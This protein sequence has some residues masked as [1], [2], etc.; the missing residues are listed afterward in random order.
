[1]EKEPQK[2]SSR[3]ALPQ[4]WVLGVEPET[5]RQKSAHFWMSIA[6]RGTILFVIL[7]C[8]FA[9][10]ISIIQDGKQASHG[11]QLLSVLF[12]LLGGWFFG[13]KSN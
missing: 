8:A 7:L 9:A 1:M 5:Q 13:R 11:W 2:I 3:D 10:V 4:S 6:A 12:G